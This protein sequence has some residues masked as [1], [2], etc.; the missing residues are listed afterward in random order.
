MTAT[1]HTIYE[2]QKFI[3]VCNFN[4]IE[5]DAW[6]DRRRLPDGNYEL[7]GMGR[8]T[9]YDAKTGALVSDKT[10]P[11]GL[12]GWAPAEAIDGPRLPWWCRLFGT[13]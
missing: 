9:E 2:E 13:A 11:T 7:V 6:I 12:R 3:L 8:R 4:R 1:I 10:E 5:C